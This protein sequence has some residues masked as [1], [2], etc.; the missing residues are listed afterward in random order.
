VEARTNLNVPGY[1][2]AHE[3]LASERQPSR[4]ETWRLVIPSEH[5]AALVHRPLDLLV[6]DLPL[7]RELLHFSHTRS[8]NVG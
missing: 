6:I 1:K 7:L 8:Q 3:A 2:S 5:F 4:E